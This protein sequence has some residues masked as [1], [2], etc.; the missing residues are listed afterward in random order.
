[1]KYREKPIHIGFRSH[2]TDYEQ[3]YD[4]GS[5]HTW[6]AWEEYHNQEMKRK[7]EI[8]DLIPTDVFNKMI[9]DRG[10]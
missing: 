7:Q 8:I 4:A 9:T 1:M 6:G 3:G 10:M 2:P 5:D